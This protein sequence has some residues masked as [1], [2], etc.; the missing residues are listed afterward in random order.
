M[1]LI[2]TNV[3]LFTKTHLHHFLFHIFYVLNC[4]SFPW[5]HFRI[6]FLISFHC[7]FANSIILTILPMISSIISLHFRVLLHNFEEH[8]KF[9]SKVYGLTVEMWHMKRVKISWMQKFSSCLTC[10]LN[11]FLYNGSW[12]INVTTFVQFSFVPETKEKDN[13]IVQCLL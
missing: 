12:F 6:I 1:H 11:W 9:E 13:W 7:S 10:F 5:S 4:F 2:F 8:Q 3:Y